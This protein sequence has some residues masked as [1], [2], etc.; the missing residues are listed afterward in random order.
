MQ[1]VL[2]I[3][4][5]RHTRTTPQTSCTTLTPAITHVPLSKQSSHPCTLSHSCTTARTCIQVSENKKISRSNQP[6]TVTTCCAKKNQKQ[7]TFNSSKSP[8]KNKIHTI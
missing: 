1:Y 3:K 7:K 5:T 6:L 4:C 8:A 2:C